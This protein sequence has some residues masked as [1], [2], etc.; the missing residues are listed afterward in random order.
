MASGFRRSSVMLRLLPFTARKP[1][2]I[3][4]SDQSPAATSWWRVSS[5]LRRLHGGARAGRRL[6][7][8][9]RELERLR[10]R[11]RVERLARGVAERKIAEEKP[12]HAAVLD[13]VLRRAHDHGRDAVRFEVAGDQTHG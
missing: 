9:K 4:R 7:H 6:E 12:R 10:L 3:L 2:G 1:G 11:L 5:P 8:A 13:D